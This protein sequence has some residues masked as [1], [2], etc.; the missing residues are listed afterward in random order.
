MT[1]EQ[2]QQRMEQ[3]R[4]D[5]M[6]KALD[7]TAEQWKALEPKVQKVEALQREVNMLAMG[8]GMPF[9]GRGM[10]GGRGGPGGPNAMGPQTELSKAVEEL[11]ATLDNKDS[12]PEQIS[13]KL[14]ALRD[15]RAQAPAELAKVRAELLQSLTPRQEAQL[16]LMGI[17][18]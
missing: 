17:L 13:A 2:M 10:M 12:T 1:P 7:I 5:R 11:Q 16:V 18:Q 6:T 14:K 15:A 9:G 8:G 3:Q 4:T